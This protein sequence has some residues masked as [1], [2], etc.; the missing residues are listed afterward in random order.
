MELDRDYALLAKAQGCPVY[1]RAP[2]V[3]VQADFINGLASE[4]ATA[5]SKTGCA[6]GGGACETRWSQCPYHR[7]EIAA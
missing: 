3:G 5:L 4:V 7:G 6:P 2:A 1:L